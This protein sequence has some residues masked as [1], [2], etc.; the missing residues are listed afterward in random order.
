MTDL[1]PEGR[2]LKQEI[3]D[4]LHEVLSYPSDDGKGTMLLQRVPLI[5]KDIREINEKLDTIMPH[6]EATVPIVKEYQERQSA[7]AFAKRYGDTVKWGGGII[8]TI[9]AVWALFFKQ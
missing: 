7:R 9:A 4:A 1:N 3:V 6:I 8:L 2:T 5:C